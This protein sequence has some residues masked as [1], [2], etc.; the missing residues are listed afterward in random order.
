MHRTSN[1]PEIVLDWLVRLRWLAVI[2]QLGAT[3]VSTLL[4]DLELPLPVIAVLV[5]ITLASNGALILLRRFGRTPEWMLPTVVLFDVL[6]LS[7]VLFFTGGTKNP[8]A[9]LF[10][11]HVAVG[12]VVLSPVWT[13]VIFALSITAYAMLSFLN[14]P[15]LPDGRVLPYWASEVGGW[16]ALVL[17]SGLTVYFIGRLQSSLRQREQEL[18]STRE[19]VMRSERLASVTALAAGAAHELGSPLGTIAV[20]AR[21]L[22]LNASRGAPANEISEDAQLIREEVERC[23][24]ILNRM[25]LEVGD[26]LRFQPSAVSA[27][28]FIDGACVDLVDERKAQVVADVTPGCEQIF[29]PSRAILRAVGVLLRNGFEASR[30]GASITLRVSRTGNFAEAT[31]IDTGHGMPPDVLKRAGEPFFT[32]KEMG[33][34]MGMGLFIVKLIAEQ[35]GGGVRMESEAGRGTTATIYWPEN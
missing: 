21:E 6:M 17:T 35:N 1:R 4:L 23:R 11:V 22:E 33:R 5:G 14:R 10:I 8:F 9:I 29:L 32:T 2:G 25:R 26:D 34:G 7:T 20:V 18:L 30:P 15:L 13:W 24:A 28:E 19:R 27:Q 31:V 3:T 12:V 16:L